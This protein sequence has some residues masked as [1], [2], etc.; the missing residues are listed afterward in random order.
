MNVA[1]S[2]EELEERS[3]GLDGSCRNLIDLIAIGS[4]GPTAVVSKLSKE[5]AALLN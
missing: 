2:R 3:C 5:M 4:P 1:L